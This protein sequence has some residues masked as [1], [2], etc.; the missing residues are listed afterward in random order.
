ME[1]ISVVNL[2]GG[3]GKTQS[4]INIASNLNG[5]V[6]FIDLDPQ[7]NSTIQMGV[8]YEYT[9]YDFFVNQKPLE[10]LVIEVNS[11]LDFVPSDLQSSRTESRT[12][13]LFK[14][15]FL[16]RKALTSLK[17]VYNYVVI[18][19]PPS[20]DILTKNACLSADSIVV[21]VNPEPHAVSGLYYLEQ[22]LEEINCVIDKVFITMYDKRTKI[23]VDIVDELSKM[24]P[25]KLARNIIRR[26]TI[27]NESVLHQSNL[28]E[29]SPK[30]E[31][32]NDYDR[33][34]KELIK[35][36]V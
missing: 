1:I 26:G 35:Q 6:L 31:V 27:V 18:D 5:K 4:A 19:C 22:A 7:G 34:T 20:F 36:E 9:M 33:L 11:M 28:R 8:E 32:T 10:E 29:F 14:R 30:S 17:D 15:E 3:V 21:P 13:G 12:A 23:H 2:K 25:F 16:L 24:Y